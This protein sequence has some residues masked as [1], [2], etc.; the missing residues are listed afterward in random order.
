M[1]SI[2]PESDSEYGIFD[3]DRFIGSVTTS[4]NPYHAKNIYL[5]IALETYDV[6]A[7]AGLFGRLRKLLGRPMQV[8]LESGNTNQA[9]WLLA[10]GFKRAR[11]C[12]ETQVSADDLKCS[13]GGHMLLEKATQGSEEYRLCCEMLYHSYAKTHEAVSPLTASL[14]EFCRDLPENA[15]F[16]MENGQITHWA[17]VEENEIAYVGTNVPGEFQ[18]FAET[19]LSQMLAEHGNIFFKCDDCDPAAMGLRSFFALPD[20][21]YCDTYIFDE[22]CDAGKREHG[23]GFHT[24]GQK[25]GT[26]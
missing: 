6:A 18:P 1:I 22:G 15:V 16:H 25:R 3:A 26:A 21:P 23:S 8:M 19:L 24:V 9:A 13:I 11:R 5:H 14:E 10:G 2:V 7:A 4:Q 20:A 17:F 12:Y